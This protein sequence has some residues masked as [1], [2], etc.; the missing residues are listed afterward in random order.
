MPDKNSP[1]NWTRPPAERPGFRQSM[2]G[3]HTWSGIILGGLMFVIFLFGTI[4]FFQHEISAWMRPELSR[5]QLSH[6]GLVGAERL[7]NHVAPQARQWT[8]SLPTS[9]AGEPVKV[10]WTPQNNSSLEP[11]EADIDPNT[12]LGINVRDTKGGYFLYRFHYDLHYIPVTWARYL[13]CIAALVMLVTILSGIITHKRIFRDFFLL[14]LGKGQRSWADGHNGLAV[15]ALPFHL[16]ISYTGLVT[17]LFT[18]MPWAIVANFPDQR[19]YYDSVFPTPASPL[20]TGAPASMIRLTD[21]ARQSA[22]HGKAIFPLYITIME[23]NTDR[24]VIEIWP[25]ADSLGATRRP[26]YF[27]GVTGDLLLAA[28]GRGSV[29]VSRDVMVHLHAARFARPVLRWLYFIAGLCGTV[30]IATGLILWAIKRRT[31]VPDQNRLPFGRRLVERLNIGVII[32]SCAGIAV[33]FLANRLLPLD[34]AHRADWEIN[35]LFI[36]WGGLFV[37]TLARPAKRAWIEALTVCAALY[38]LVPAVN[39]LT[40]ARGLVP[41]LVARDWAFAGFDLVMLAMAAVCAFSAWKIAQH[42]PKA[43]L[44]RRA[45]ELVEAAQ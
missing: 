26:S 34:I 21:I 41:S 15:V 42:K 14:R 1:L 24:S 23:P 37:W 25:Q 11:G 39:A 8:V 36:A 29:T 13:V 31:M 30:M 44:R 32:G 9:R 35:S 5:G 2:A 43:A 40:T 6:D 12:G 10:R 7:L 4:A 28:P 16:M 38:A 3:L 27:N 18:L 22:T 45:R 19:S 33:Y 17:L 20:G